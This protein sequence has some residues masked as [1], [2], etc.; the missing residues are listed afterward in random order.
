MG[1]MSGMT[2]NVPQEKNRILPIDMY[3]REFFYASKKKY[4][5]MITLYEENKESIINK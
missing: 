3:S 5:D 4:E 1:G 2:N